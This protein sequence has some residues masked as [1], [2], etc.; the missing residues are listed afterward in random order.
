VQTKLA[1]ARELLGAPSPEAQDT[2]DLS[3]QWWERL[4]NLTGI[5]VLACPCCRTGRL[6]RT[7]FAPNEF[8]SVPAV[9]ILDTS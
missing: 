7:P 2:P 3:G 4:F 8:S 6:V 5:D 1:L 9:P